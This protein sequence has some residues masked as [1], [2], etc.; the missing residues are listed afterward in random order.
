MTNQ[1]LGMLEVAAYAAMFIAACSLAFSL[2][3]EIGTTQ[4]SYYEA[5][6]MQKN[7]LTAY[8]I[9]DAGAPRSAL[10][11]LTSA[12]VYYML[13]NAEEAYLIELEGQSFVSGRQAASQVI[14]QSLADNAMYEAE[15]EY[16]TEGEVK[17]IKL[18]KE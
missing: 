1:T 5:R 4:K 7:N 9:H 11:R 17:L 18:S 13:T 14:L 12:Q 2:Q 8:E 10:L 15:Y 6:F 16:D 3:Q